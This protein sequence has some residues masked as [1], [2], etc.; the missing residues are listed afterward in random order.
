MLL[1]RQPIMKSIVIQEGEE[2]C[3]LSDEGGK[4]ELISEK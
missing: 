3:T 1:E 2:N 4:V